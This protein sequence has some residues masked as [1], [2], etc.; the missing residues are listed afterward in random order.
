MLRYHLKI[1]K[2]EAT[3]W[4]AGIGTGV[5]IG[6]AVRPRALFGTG[7]AFGKRNKLIIDIGGIYMFYDKLSNAV[8]RIGNIAIP[9]D[10]TVSASKMQL[11]FSLGYTI[12]LD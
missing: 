4:H 1:K 2:T 9:E 10:Y 7:L 6:P 3:F 12:S 8:E 11:Y 5:N